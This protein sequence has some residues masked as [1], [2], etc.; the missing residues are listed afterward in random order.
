M[1]KELFLEP[2]IEVLNF[3][4]FMAGEEND[5]NSYDGGAGDGVDGGDLLG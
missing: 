3:L 4:C 1:K 5:F 2:E